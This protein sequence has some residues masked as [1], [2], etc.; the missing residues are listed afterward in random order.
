ML[1][2][3]K[4]IYGINEHILKVAMLLIVL[5]MFVTVADVVG[6][7]LFKPIPGTFELTRLALAVIVFTSL[8]YSQIHKV[9]IAINILV[10]RLPLKVQN[11]IEVLN[12]IISLATFSIVV[13]QMLKYAERL[14]GVNQVTAVLRAHVHPWVIVSAVG[15]LFFCLVLVW[16][17]IVGINKLKGGGMDEYRSPWSS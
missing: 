17:L 16:D 2:L 10:S 4:I 7:M 11:V 13:W 9:H 15:V 8:G 6:R 14:A 3:K 5:M 12:T 1:L